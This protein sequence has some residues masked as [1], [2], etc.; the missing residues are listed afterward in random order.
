MSLLTFSFIYDLNCI[1]YFILFLSFLI[2]LILSKHFIEKCYS[3]S[4]QYRI[5]NI[6]ENSAILPEITQLFIL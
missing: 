6:K 1:F 5:L 3:F 2:N 4:L